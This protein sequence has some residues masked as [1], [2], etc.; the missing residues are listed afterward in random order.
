MVYPFQLYVWLYLTVAFLY[1][2]I[3]AVPL[4]G[5]PSTSNPNTYI[6]LFK[7]NLSKDVGKYVFVTM[8]VR[9]DLI[10]KLV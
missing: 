10:N 3:L 6:V 8:Y 7:E 2:C 1:E 4:K 9:S 5:T